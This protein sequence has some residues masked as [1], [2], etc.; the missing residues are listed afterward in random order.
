MRSL[1]RTTIRGACPG[2]A[3]FFLAAAPGL[4]Q[5]P[6]VLTDP[7]FE[8][9]IERG[10]VDVPRGSILIQDIDSVWTATGE[11]LEGVDILIRDGVI[12]EIGPDLS[13][14]RGVKTLDASGHTAIPGFVD[15]HSHIA[16]T[17]SNECT[18]PIVPEVRVIDQLDPEDFG[19]FRALTG[20]V[21]TAQV[22]HGSCNPIG[23]QNA[24]I[25]PRWGLQDPRQFL[26]QGA[27]QTVKFAL[28]ENVTRKNWG[29]D[30]PTR[31][32][33]SRQGVEAIYVE[34]FT[35]AQAYQAEWQRYEENPGSFRVPPRRDFRLQA[36]VDIMEGRIRVHAHSYRADEILML[37]GVAE[38]FGFK[39][40]CFTH[41]LEGYKVADEMARHGACG[42]TFSDW[43]HYKLEA[44]DAIPY[45]AAIM[46]DH[47][48]LTSLNS[49]SEQLQTFALYEIQKPVR[50]GGVS[51]EDAL[52]M[53]TLYSAQQLMIADR[54][55]SLEVGKDGDVVLLS[56]DPFDSASRVEK[57][58]M[59]GILYWDRT[60][61]AE[62]RHTPMRTLPELTGE[63]MAASVT[64]ATSR[65]LTDDEEAAATPEEDDVFALVGATIHTGT[66]PAIEN[67]T[68]VVRNGRIEAVGTASEVTV[69]A[70]AR[71]IAVSGELFPG[72]TDLS[73]GLGLQEV[74]QVQTATDQRETGT[75]NPHLRAMI[76]MQPHSVTYNVARANGVTTAVTG[77]QAGVIPGAGSLLQLRGDTPQRLSILDRAAMII[78]F[79]GPSGSDWEEPALEGRD[80][81]ELV[82]LFRRAVTFAE[83]PTTRDDPDAPFEA[84]VH[85]GE[86][87]MLEALA[88]VV[89][90]EMPAFFNVSD[91]RAIRT[92]LLFL[93]EFPDVEAVIVG[94]AEAHRVAAELG[95]RGIPVALNTGNNVTRDRDDP[96]DAA[97]TNA[98]VLHEAGVPIAFTTTDVSSVRNLAHFA[99]RHRAYGLPY[100][101]AIR[102]VTLTPAEI[103]GVADEMGSITPGKRADL[104]LADGDILQI[105]TTV[106]RMWIG[107]EEV[108]PRDNK[109]YELYEEFRDRH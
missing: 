82:D 34:A 72:L 60:A 5:T 79:P 3:L 32:P 39:I 63:T 9:Q 84:Q 16:M 104:V 62:Y 75:Y 66:G 53:Y 1:Y 101:V 42:S 40:D 22:L 11:V 81:E 56:G 18:S 45:N 19:I 90:G 80:L 97:W 51:K 21:T 103:L 102:A 29:G 54:V 70:G 65:S 47:G 71:R 31:F 8:V 46:H 7:G 98:A 48:V 30:G 55:G 96:H 68:V 99:A 89:T 69:P 4:A 109:H 108:D 94:G 17:T 78:N 2:A 23:G 107:G 33:L 85:G 14:P 77:Q 24:I 52:R 100:D 36:L 10:A 57:T 91:E 43:W 61:E 26:V 67:G 15:E 95:E 64:W 83:T 50:Y 44:F 20:G 73:T 74:G 27:P 87:L 28:G 76:G 41:V 38:R 92:L 105:T 25:K 6:T 86:R 49:D 58:I 93:D 35:A 106:Q 12:R 13:A 59:D 37:I 88:P